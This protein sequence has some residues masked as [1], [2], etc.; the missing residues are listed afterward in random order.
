MSNSLVRFHLSGCLVDTSLNRI[1]SGTR[2]IQVEPKIMQVLVV[3]AEHAGEVVTRNDLMQRV[4]PDV[5]VTD[6]AL[7]R[8]IRELRRVFE[9][10]SHEP[11]VI[12]TIRKRGYR[13]LP[14]PV[15]DEAEA[16]ASPS[17]RSGER[18]HARAAMVAL[19][20]VGTLVA[21]GV[22]EDRFASR[23]SASSGRIR[24]VPLTTAPGSEVDPAL[25][26]TGRLAFVA[27]ASDGH[28]HVFVKPFG[29][30]TALQVTSGATDD[31]A[32]TWSPDDRHFAFAR[33]TSPRGA[34]EIWIGDA[35]GRQERRAG[36]C[37]S[38]NAL[39]MS[40]S[41]DGQALAIAVGEGTVP[42]PFHVEVLNLATGTRRVLTEAPAGYIGDASPAF[43]PDGRQIAFVRSLAGSIA[44]IFV[45]AADGNM[46]G[47]QR[48]TT[49]NADVLGVDWEPDGRHL[50]FSSDRAGGISLWRVAIAGGE[51]QLVAGG[52][53]KLKH[54]SVARRAGTIAYED[55]HYEINLAEVV[56]GTGD[57][58]SARIS[59]TS[60]QWNF[61][62][63]IA[64][65]N[66]RI[67]FESTRSGAYE[68]WLTD[69]G[70]ANAQQL[71][72]SGIFKSMA[73]WSPD[74]RRLAFATRTATADEVVV[75]DVT[76]KDARIVAR[77]PNGAVAPS[78]SH[79]GRAL[80]F[81]SR[82]DG[83]WQIW[84]VDMD[85]GAA[86]KI[87]ENGGYAALESLDGR[88]LYY[89]SL[90]P[91]GLWKRA[92]D[93]TNERLVSAAVRADDWADLAVMDGA[94]LFLAEPDEGDPRLMRADDSGTKAQLTRLPD[95]AWSGV[96]VSRDGARVL[97]A[98]ADHRESNIVGVR[99]GSLSPVETTR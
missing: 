14:T 82:R 53:A 88:S 40:W 74:G 56:T 86:R 12:E 28:P 90:S 79:D 96:G 50:V 77:E 94:V 20:V 33:I 98:R 92:I 42:S 8:A 43:S 97:Y 24:F 76:S 73:R 30:G 89:T 5:F 51:P 95:F 91:R 58:P 1:T 21:V 61:Y 18:W 34:C 54:P 70:G 75:L 62:P 87:T 55:W 99:L 57:A 10:V 67:A 59:P 9:D 84:R 37:G 63:Q 65:D 85:G 83:S 4:W 39:R 36:S 78:W 32:P 66:T 16:V 19:A 17:A 71:T 3:L 15:V 13:L 44:D 46:P 69:R 72:H 81:G 26:P 60:D 38:R 22:F 49:D 93:G 35:D 45:V 23:T 7:N 25:S 52:G 2:T 6:D 11:H 47:P 80:Y 29:P 31:A 64:P 48:V 41:P 68:L 27:R